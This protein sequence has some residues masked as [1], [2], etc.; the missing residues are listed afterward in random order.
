MNDKTRE[1]M[2]KAAKIIETIPSVTKA[3]V[4][5]PAVEK[6]FTFGDK[7]QLAVFTVPGD[8]YTKTFS[9]LNRA[10]FDNDLTRIELYMT[11]DEDFY[12]AVYN[13]IDKG[14]IIY[15]RQE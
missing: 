2:D 1:Y 14:E 3:V 10:L 5:G 6:N 11:A 9:D 7:I 8:K 13:L 4:V 15:E 12:A